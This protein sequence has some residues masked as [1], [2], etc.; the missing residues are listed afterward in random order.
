MPTSRSY[1]VAAIRYWRWWRL[2]KLAAARRRIQMRLARAKVLVVDE[3]GYL[4]F[5]RD[6]E[7]VFFKVVAE[8]C[9]RGSMVLTSNLPFTQWGA[10]ADDRTLTANDAGPADGRQAQE[11]FRG[12]GLLTAGDEGERVLHR[13]PFWVP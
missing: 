11:Q 9:E 3:I 7:N 4:P 8:R 6:E 5:G 1:A 12:F 13:V 2:L 10:F